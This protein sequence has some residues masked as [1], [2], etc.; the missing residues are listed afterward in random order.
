MASAKN[1]TT[2]FTLNEFP[3]AFSL[4]R[5]PLSIGRRCF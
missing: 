4:V 3:V 5:E 1:H 2:D